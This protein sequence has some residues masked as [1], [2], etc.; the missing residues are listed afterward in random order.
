MSGDLTG[1]CLYMIELHLMGMS[2]VLSVLGVVSGVKGQGIYI[3]FLFFI[4]L[5]I[6]Q[7]FVVAV[8]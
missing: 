3:S 7:S 8:F 2:C 4:F 1:L 6:L 5:Q